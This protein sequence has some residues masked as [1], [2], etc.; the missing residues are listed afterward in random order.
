MFPEPNGLKLEDGGCRVQH[1]REEWQSDQHEL[2]SI[3][4]WGRP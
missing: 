3:E 1:E 4:F 2:M